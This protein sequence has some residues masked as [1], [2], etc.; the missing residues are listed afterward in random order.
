VPL[1]RDRVPVRSLAEEQAALRRVATLVAEGAPAAQV[2]NAV[3]EEVA[4]VM[5]LGSAAVS[6]FDDDGAAMTIVAVYDDRPHGFRPGTRWPL[7]G[8]SMSAEVLRTGR[9]A[10]VV[11][12]TDISSSLAA[13]ARESGLN[14]IVGA[15]IIVNGRVWGVISTAS[16]EAPFPDD[17][18]DRLAEFTELV[19]T[20]IANSQA[21]EELTRLVEDQAALRRVATLA[22]QGA[23]PAEVFAAVS[24]EVAR[25]IPAD[26][27]AL[28]RF[29]A[30]GTVTALSGWTSSGGY[31]YVGKRY[32]LEGTVS[33]LVYETHEPA[34]IDN[35]A[36][37]PG[38]AA[39]AGQ[40]MGW[41]SSVGVPITVEGR[42]WGVL[43][44]VSTTAR[45]LPHDTERRV[46][47]FT[48][49]VASAIANAEGRKEVTRLAEEQAAL[50]RVAT[51]VAERTTPAEIFEAVIAEVG[52][53]IPAA[54]AAALTRYET[55]E[56]VT[57]IG[58]WSRT[59][60]YVAVGARHP[61]GRGTLGRLVFET[62]RPGRIDSYE[63]ASGSLASVVRDEM[64]W[65]SAVGAPI[66]VEGRLWGVLGIGSTT[67][68]L[69]PHD[70]EERLAEFTDL[71]ATALA[72]TE[73]R[74]ELRVRSEEQAALRRV[75]TLVARG[76][77]ASEILDAV[78]G[79]VDRLLDADW[80]GVHRY[81]PDG[82]L[83]VLAS[84]GN[85][86]PDIPVGA[87]VMLNSESESESVA[88]SVKRT[89]RS[90]RIESFEGLP[91]AWAA[92]GRELGARSAV[93]APITVEGELWGVAIAVWTQPGPVP[94]VDAERLLAGFTELVATAIANAE[95]REELATLADEQAALRRVA[96]LVAEGARPDEVFAAVA[97]EVALLLGVPIA[98]ML[99]FDP[100][101]MA[102]V[103]ASA[104]A[105]L[106]P[107]GTRWPIEGPSLAATVLE[108][109][110]AAR[111]DDFSEARGAIAD[112]V[113]QMGV[114][115]AV[116]V[117]IIVDG[118]LWGVMTTGSCEAEPVTG[119]LE[120]RLAK[121]TQL[122]A[123]AIANAESRG[124]LD[125]S[126]ARIVATADATRRRIERDLHDGAQQRL[127]SLAL[128][129]RAVQAS[130]PPELGGLRAEL[131]RVAAGHA[132]VL[133]E[134]REIARGI[135][136]AV[137]ADGGLRPALK[138]LARRSP[139]PV[140][141]DARVEG[142]LPEPVEV[143]AFYVVSEALANVAKYA[144]ASVVQVA[145]GTR[146][147]ILY[148]SVRDDG[149][150]GADPAVGSGL[151]GLK[152]RAE[153]IGGTISLDSPPGAGTSLVV[154]LPVA[155]P[156]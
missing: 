52:R 12:Y 113:R 102:T 25:L 18:E 5:G 106:G 104:G 51:L 45:Q 116:A 114:R 3:A 31:V 151:L 2:F 129:V 100:D 84:H 107:A 61:L 56:T 20:A 148:V 140:E 90:A 110:R 24:A 83:T 30:D 130:V 62:C 117:P 8:P 6:R 63:G 75:A 101:G 111:M 70:S 88:A 97:D 138:T 65:R 36:D 7:D 156:S 123:T 13:E 147:G 89:G 49:L 144:C 17:V 87:R 78:A 132:D 155:E 94:I 127:V 26:G 92:R 72:N 10:R 40:E 133:D 73:S 28:T 44:V 98:V 91:G 16:P 150:G 145:V 131:S 4:Q 152:D 48:E 29:E 9:P 115:W 109:G 59:N 46:A 124:E 80:A 120:D 93:G 11:D 136:P 71:V 103:L 135:H 22:A 128:E 121:F 118:A 149:L 99:R 77:P 119:G 27:A 66:V 82:A 15:P 39:A 43:A 96:T 67:D 21:R 33:G 81:D 58:G 112:A 64:G 34:R 60:G 74:E 54:D 126:R 35:Y 86:T 95:S 32:A 105:E 125:S 122:L 137:L 139:V 154:E 141:L 146:D 37:E 42:L 79:E 50:R 134:L 14:R 143:A 85:L 55:D 76:G 142:R 68:S 38:E 153:A 57:I 23:A 47:D 1:V 41:R 69:L 19:A 53:L 108:T